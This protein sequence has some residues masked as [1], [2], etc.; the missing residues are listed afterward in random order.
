MFRINRRTVVFNENKVKEK[1]KGPLYV[2][3]FINNNNKIYLLSIIIGISLL[4]ES[5]FF[6]DHF[7]VY[8]NNR[9]QYIYK[10]MQRKSLYIKKII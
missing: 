3:F 4:Q 10:M 2:E 8:N 6:R 9:T 7:C 5:F 1:K